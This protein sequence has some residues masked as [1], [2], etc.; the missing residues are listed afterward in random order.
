MQRRIIEAGAA[1][2]TL[3][4]CCQ[5]VPVK[6]CHGEPKTAAGITVIRRVGETWRIDGA[7]W[8]EA[9]ATIS[10]LEEYQAIK[11]EFRGVHIDVQR[12]QITEAM[13]PA[14]WSMHHIRATLWPELWKQGDNR[15]DLPHPTAPYCTFPQIPPDI[16]RARNAVSA[17][18]SRAMSSMLDRNMVANGPYIFLKCGHHVPVHWKSH[19]QT[20]TAYGSNWGHCVCFVLNPSAT[21]TGPTATHQT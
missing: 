4:E 20:S 8:F 6:V 17:S 12:D 9:S 18:M 15:K 7:P 10:T 3:W 16:K 13:F 11:R 1:T 21:G 14:L 2:K 5:S 19:G